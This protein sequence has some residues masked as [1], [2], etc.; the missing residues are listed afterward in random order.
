MNPLPA[1]PPPRPPRTPGARALCL[2]AM[3]PQKTRK[4]A[5]IIIRP[6]GQ[7]APHPL[8]N[9][10]RCGS[11]D[12]ELT[13]QDDVEAP[14]GEE[15]VA[16]GDHEAGELL[17]VGS[18]WD[19]RRVGRGGWVG[20]D[21]TQYACACG[22][23]PPTQ[24]G[25]HRSTTHTH[26]QTHLRRQQLVVA[27]KEHPRPPARHLFWF[28]YIATVATPLS[29]SCLLAPAAPR[30]GC[31]WL[32]GVGCGWCHQSVVEVVLHITLLAASA[33][34]CL[35]AGLASRTKPPAS[36]RHDVSDPDSRRHTTTGSRSR[37]D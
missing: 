2:C 20:R 37:V 36:E 17:G 5:R 28:S 10:V 7:S 25:V 18:V 26:T 34:A 6:I 11:F 27:L 1:W 14:L 19:R 35:L 8:P 3:P 30:A 16:G 31:F 15:P 22:T 13:A 33:L 29:L 12:R 24:T 21:R 32:G 23:H 4:G 9:S